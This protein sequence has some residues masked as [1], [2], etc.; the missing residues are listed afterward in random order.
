MANTWNQSGTT[1]NTGRWGTTEAIT[2]GWGA[3][4]WNTGGSWGQATDELVSVTGVS[5]TVSVGDV[6][7]GANQGWGR[8]GWSE[9]PYGESDNPVVTL[10][11]FGLTTS[12]GT[13]ESFNETGWGRLTW[14][15][16]DWGEGA[17][18]TVSLTGIEATASPGSITMGVTYLLEMIG[19]NH[20]MTT[21]VGSL[22]VD[23]EIVVPLTGVSA[24]FATPTMSY[25]GTL[26]GWGRDAWGDNSW[27][28][29]PNQV[30]P[31]VGREATASVGSPTLEFAY[32]LSGQEA[33]TNVG[34]VSFVISPTISLTGQSATVSVGDLG[35]AFG[36]STEPI[37]GVAATFSLGT[38]GLEFGPSE[39]T[40]VS[41]TASVGELTTGAIE[42][43]DLT[44][45]S[46]TASV[47]SISPADVI[48]L[49]GVSA[50]ISV[51]T[52]TPSENVQGLTTD[53]ITSSVGII[54]IQAYANV[55]TG[56]NTSYTDVAT[57]SNN[58]YSDV[59]TG[60]NT[61]YSDAA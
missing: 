15:Q 60:S 57:G 40:G 24:T 46:A 21:S 30:I 4:A 37:S 59:A 8:A 55:D 11:G 52:I 14:N 51:G 25:V 3:D 39:I 44:G 49:T 45:V 36:V 38:L 18:E 61:S 31:L 50:T 43:L 42:L 28:E 16:A 2:S 33:T 13:T 26:V 29:S 7:S 34:S 10:T 56:S 27:G 9:E 47:G 35:L 19:A 23:G 54:G 22:Q 12:L 6:V 53:Q 32:E 1:W 58:T 17:D 41:A 20:S 48:G 5:A